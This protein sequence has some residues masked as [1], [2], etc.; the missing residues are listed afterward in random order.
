[1]FLESIFQ[2]MFFICLYGFKI[3]GK[4]VFQLFMFLIFLEKDFQRHKPTTL[5]FE[6]FLHAPGVI[7][8]KPF[9]NTQYIFICL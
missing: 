2:K 8:H 4:I 3:F 5:T 6:H 9:E 7:D 1:M